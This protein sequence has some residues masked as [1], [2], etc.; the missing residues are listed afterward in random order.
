MYVL[1][2]MVTDRQ[3]RGQ[4]EKRVH[5]TS[6]L[7]CRNIDPYVVLVTIELDKR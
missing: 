4:K 7:V 3:D 6:G 5:V 2:C 1:S